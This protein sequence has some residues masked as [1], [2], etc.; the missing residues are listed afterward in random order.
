MLVEYY[1]GEVP[2]P[3][4]YYEDM[5]I[6]FHTLQSEYN[7]ATWLT[8]QGI[9]AEPFH[10]WTLEQLKH[11]VNIERIPVI[12][13]VQISTGGHFILIT[14]ITDGIV[15]AHDPLRGPHYPYP[16]EV[17][18]EMWEY[19]WSW[20]EFTGIVPNEAPDFTT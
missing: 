2:H 12:A 10:D 19:E 9:P 8:M 5:N 20:T 17:F 11:K 4:Q 15:F 14:G 13:T 1:T 6:P 3:F 7:I 16:I 18:M